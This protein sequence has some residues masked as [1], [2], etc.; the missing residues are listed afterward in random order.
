MACVMDT[1]GSFD[2]IGTEGCPKCDFF[3]Y[4]FTINANISIEFRHFGPDKRISLSQIRRKEPL[5]VFQRNARLFFS[6][7][8][9]LLPFFHTVN[10]RHS[11]SWQNL[12]ELK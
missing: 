8:N 5:A 4:S 9:P 7:S 12:I 1:E 10:V 3:F 2:L 6:T 11:V